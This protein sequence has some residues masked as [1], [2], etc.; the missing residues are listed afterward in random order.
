MYVDNVLDPSS[1]FIMNK[2]LYPEIGDN[3]VRCNWSEHCRYVLVQNDSA[4]ADPGV[5]MG[6]MLPPVPVKISH[7]KDGCRR[8]P[9]RFHISC[10][11]T[12]PLDRLLQ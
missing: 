1:Q 9:H 5:V 4:V 12:C 3:C 2:K 8:W 7:K 11:P 10:P 6:A